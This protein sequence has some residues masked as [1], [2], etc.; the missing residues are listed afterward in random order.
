MCLWIVLQGREEYHRQSQPPLYLQSDTSSDHGSSAAIDAP[1]R[2]SSPH[3]QRSGIRNETKA[4]KQ[5]IETVEL[6]QYLGSGRSTVTFEVKF[7]SE[8]SS[9]S[10]QVQGKSS[11][12][13]AHV[14]KFSGDHQEDYQ[15]RSQMEVTVAQILS[16][17]PGI[18]QTV[19]FDPDVE[20]PFRTGLIQLPTQI[21]QEISKLTQVNKTASKRQYDA[22]YHLETN[23]RM[24]IAVM[25]RA[26]ATHSH[27]RTDD[28][29]GAV[30]DLPSTS[31][32]R[33]FWKRLFETLDYVN[34]KQILWADTNLWNVLLQNGEIVFFDWN[35]A[36][37][38]TTTKKDSSLQQ[39]EAELPNGYELL[40]SGDADNPH[41]LVA[42]RQIPKIAKRIRE[43]LDFV[44]ANDRDLEED[45]AKK[46]HWGELDRLCQSML[47]KQTKRSRKTLGWFLENDNYFRKHQSELQA[48][49]L[50]W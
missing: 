39:H 29:G 25:E 38:Y 47:D 24:S 6:G 12:K 3:K 32:V 35:G 50:V 26:M 33:C 31:L 14:I 2:L 11:G 16:P 21:R 40:D 4:S 7:K 28:A 46:Q 30:L 18:P 17:H 41:G 22:L 15:Q 45:H 1:T 13:N 36:R 20:N 23:Q 49:S 27:T 42:S 10:Y 8:E 34:A 48:C 44:K 37:I 19:L 5:G 43:Y 9:E